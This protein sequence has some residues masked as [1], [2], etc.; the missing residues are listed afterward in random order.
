MKTILFYPPNNEEYGIFEDAQPLDYP[1]GLC[2]IAAVLEKHGHEVKI[3]D[4]AHDKRLKG[5][6]SAEQLIRQEKPDV[7]GISCLTY[8][9]KGAFRIAGIAKAIDNNIKVWMGGPHATFFPGQILEHVPS[10][11]IIVTGE[12]ED[13]VDELIGAIANGESIENIDGLAFRDEN[14]NIKI[15]KTREWS[16][17][18]NSL[19]MPAHHQFADQIREKKW[20][21]VIGNRGCPFGCNFC[22]TTYFWGLRTRKRDP[23]NVIDEVD[24]LVKEYGV[25]NIYFE[26]DTFSIDQEWAH[27]ICEEIIRRNLKIKWQAITRFNCITKE[28]LAIMKESG[29][30]RLTFGLE[31]GAAKI[32]NNLHKGLNRQVVIKGFELLRGSGIEVGLFMM[33]GNPGEDEE[34]IRETCELFDAVGYYDV[35]SISV[36]QLFPNT[37]FYYMARE[38][39]LISDEFW[40]KEDAPIPYY[41]GEH[42]LRTLQKYTLQIIMHCQRRKGIKNFVKFSVNAGKRITMRKV[43]ELKQM[44]VV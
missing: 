1:L 43:K 31:S 27:E 25:E 9:R 13:T 32:L 2:Y 29:C 3:F 6:N 20:A 41:L 12:S 23:K 37:P 28:L 38:K 33:V 22:S 8:N 10:V 16:P 11:D 24:H 14:G 35:E 18:I 15:N 42:D 21:H 30:K 5:L 26:D 17:D 36:L 7:V 44:R 19:P 34:T 4:L 40:V 39:G